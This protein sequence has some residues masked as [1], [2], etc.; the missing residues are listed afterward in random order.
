MSTLDERLEQYG[1]VSPSCLD[2]KNL[3]ER[4]EKRGKISREVVRERYG[5]FT[6]AQWKELLYEKRT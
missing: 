6:Y 3:L 5:K 2:Y 1:D 4:V